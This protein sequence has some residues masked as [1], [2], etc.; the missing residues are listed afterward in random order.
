MN[1]DY[2]VGLREIYKIHYPVGTE[3]KV[4]IN[5]EDVMCKVVSESLH[6]VVLTNGTYQFCIS[7]ADLYYKPVLEEEVDE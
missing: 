2:A 5:K 6:F 1:N 4:K 7:K 3:I